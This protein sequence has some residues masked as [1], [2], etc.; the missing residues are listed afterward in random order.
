L[1]SFYFTDSFEQRRR[2]QNFDAKFPRDAEVPLVKRYHVSYSAKT[3]MA[4]RLVP[5]PACRNGEHGLLDII[6]AALAM[7]QDR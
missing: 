6:L 3:P 2:R 1:L 4:G 7:K 5:L